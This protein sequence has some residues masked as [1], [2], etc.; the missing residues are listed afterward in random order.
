MPV[1]RPTDLPADLIQVRSFHFDERQ[2]D[3]FRDG[4]LVNE[5][6]ERY[7]DLFDA[8]DARIL[9]S[10]HQRR[11]HFCE[12]LTA[13]LLYESLGMRSLLEKYSAK[14]HPGKRKVLRAILPTPIADWVD[15]N[16]DGQPDLFSYL[17]GGAS[18]FFCEVKGPSDVVMDKQWQWARRLHDVLRHHQIDPRGR[19]QI[20]TLSR[21]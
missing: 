14:S 16:Q 10:A 13:V 5:W 17:P 4:S 11:Y 20:M 15:A 1:L 18:W 8:D 3:R 2:R 6:L 7:P 9:E 12:A 21:F 19:L